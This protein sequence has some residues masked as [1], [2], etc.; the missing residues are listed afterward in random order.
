MTTNTTKTAIAKDY[1]ALTKPR[2]TW[3]IVVTTTVGYF[4]GAKHGPWDGATILRLAHT[5]TGTGIAGVGDRC[6]E[7]VVRTGI[8]RQNA[9]Y[10]PPTASG[11]KD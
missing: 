2:I 8:R 6:A 9:P 1:L 5:L 7:R 11:R 10:L 3:L 4:F